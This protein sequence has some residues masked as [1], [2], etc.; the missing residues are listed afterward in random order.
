VGVT[1]DPERDRFAEGALLV[2]D[3]DVGEVEGVEDQLDTATDQG[4]IDLVGVAC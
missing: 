2:A 3:L 4:G 1:A